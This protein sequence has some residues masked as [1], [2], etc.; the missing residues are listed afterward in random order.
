M[1][2][3]LVARRII[4]APVFGLALALAVTAC[5]SSGSSSSSSASTPASSSAPVGS[6]SAVPASSSPASSGNSAA[7]AQITA[8]WEKFFN[9]STPN[10]ERVTLLQNGS[11]FAG[12]IS[13]LTSLVSGLGAKV[14][15]VTLT[16]ATTATVK[17]DLTAG[18]T[19]LLNNQTGTAVLDNGV[20]KVGDASLCG[21]I[22]LVP[23]G[24]VPSACSSA[25]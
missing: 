17:Y 21:L 8:N 10:S 2:F 6:P 24:T 22:K 20:W 18:G 9:S 3:P 25:G 12:A 16:S 11:A 4:L 19:S 13:G 14:T 7:V 23:G 5:S 1:R 15:N